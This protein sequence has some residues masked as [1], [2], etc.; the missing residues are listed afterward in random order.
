MAMFTGTLQKMYETHTNKKAQG[1]KP[2]F[3][4]GGRFDYK[5]RLGFRFT[6]FSFSM[7]GG[8]LACSNIAEILHKNDKATTIIFKTHSG[9]IYKVAGIREES[10]HKSVSRFQ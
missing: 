5:P 10:T 2:Y 8:G 4:Y 7:S 1:G 9:S 3:K 6:F